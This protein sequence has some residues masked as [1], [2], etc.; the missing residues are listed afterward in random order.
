MSKLT[1]LQMQNASQT[2][3]KALLRDA[4]EAYSM[5]KG[6]RVQVITVLA[7]KGKRIAIVE[8]EAGEQFDVAWEMLHQAN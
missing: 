4:S 5:Y 8:N 7:G 6:E 2:S 3:E 1:T